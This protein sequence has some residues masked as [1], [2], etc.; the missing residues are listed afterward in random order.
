MDGFF[1]HGQNVADKAPPEKKG[2]EDVYEKGFK[3]E[4]GFDMTTFNMLYPCLKAVDKPAP[5]GTVAIIPP[6]DPGRW[7]KAMKNSPLYDKKG[8]LTPAAP[9]G[10]YTWIIY[11]TSGNKL[12]VATPVKDAF[13]IGVKHGVTVTRVSAKRVHA[14]GE[15]RKVGS[16]VVSF[17]IQS[18]T[19]MR[20]WLESRKAEDPT[21]S[22]SAL[23]DH[24]EG[25]VKE[26][27]P[28]AVFQ[29]TPFVSGEPDKATLETYHK[30]GFMLADV[31]GQTYD[32]CVA[33]IA[34]LRKR[35]YDFKFGG[36]RRRRRRRYTRRR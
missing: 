36:T 15:L 25:V 34:K 21:C 27:F 17:N 13:E 19:Y 33:T 23:E 11:S 2:C 8:I 18:G 10:I 22:R 14:A 26:L 16:E 6:I 9:D 32:Q 35:Q 29:T 7:R 3:V 20:P 24:I 28:G 1:M 5:E 30:K 31:S 4:P 12:F